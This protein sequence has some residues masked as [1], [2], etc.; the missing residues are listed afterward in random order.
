MPALTV[1]SE[2]VKYLRDSIL[3]ECQYQNFDIRVDDIKW[4]ITVP[5]IWS[6]P[7]KC[8]MRSAAIKVHLY[9]SL[10]LLCVAL[11]YAYTLLIFIGI[12]INFLKILKQY[13]NS[14]QNY[15]ECCH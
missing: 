2:S 14:L 15:N 4:I 7:A 5:A 3:K 6:D 11:Q 8:F 9:T 1:F 12:F 13:H 10:H